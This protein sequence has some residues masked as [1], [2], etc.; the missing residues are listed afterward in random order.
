[1]IYRPM[2][3]AAFTPHQQLAFIHPRDR[4]YPRLLSPLWWEELPIQVRC[5]EQ[6]Q[7]V[8]S[9]S[10]LTGHVD[11]HYRLADIQIGHRPFA[12]LLL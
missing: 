4:N 2:C 10:Q 6:T 1:M 9:G 12:C 8:I 5:Q 11:D 3:G 7:A